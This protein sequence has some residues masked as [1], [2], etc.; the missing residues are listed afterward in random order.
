M[1]CGSPRARCSG[2]AEGRLL[3][4][5][6]KGVLLGDRKEAPG[7][8][9]GSEVGEGA[10]LRMTRRRPHQLTKAGFWSLEKWGEWGKWG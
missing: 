7:R 5:S 8:E 10:G 6:G 9:G 1:L 4:N 2:V 3:W